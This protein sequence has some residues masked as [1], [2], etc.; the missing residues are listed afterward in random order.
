MVQ[1][2]YFPRFNHSPE[3]HCNC[4][5]YLTFSVLTGLFTWFWGCQK[6]KEEKHQRSVW[7]CNW[8][9]HV[10][11]FAGSCLE[12]PSSPLLP[13]VTVMWAFWQSAPLNF[14]LF[15]LLCSW[16]H[17]LAGSTT[18]S[19]FSYISI[20]RTSQ[21]EMPASWLFPRDVTWL[22]FCIS[23][24]KSCGFCVGGNC[25]QDSADLAHKYF[26]RNTAKMQHKPTV[27]FTLIVF[28]PLVENRWQ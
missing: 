1:G 10:G 12:K 13:Y 19:F 3:A 27:L 26:K 25:W 11:A 21:S 24:G 9:S 6:S 2:R 28:S 14:P 20:H 7:Y 17:I 4:L 18:F 16:L 8:V 23:N 15:P 22:Q 5:S